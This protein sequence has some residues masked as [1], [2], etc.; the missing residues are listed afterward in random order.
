MAKRSGALVQYTTKWYGAPSSSPS[1]I[2]SIF[3]ALGLVLHLCLGLCLILDVFYESLSVF[4]EVFHSQSLN[5]IKF[6][7]SKL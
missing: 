4:F 3:V 5:P 7:S 2:S 1:S 6:E